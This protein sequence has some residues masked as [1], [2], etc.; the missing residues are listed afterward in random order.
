VTRPDFPL[1]WDNSMRS[2]LVACPQKFSYE[3]LHNWK[4]LYPSVDTHAGKAFAEG[5]EVARK[6]FYL[7][8]VNPDDAI[9]DG[10]SALISAYG[11]FECPSD[12]PKSR[13]RLSEAFIYYWDTFPFHLDPAQPYRGLS[14]PMIE[15]SFALPLD[16]SLLHPITGEPIIYC[17]RAD[18]VATYAGGVTIYDDKTTKSLGP[19]WGQKWDMRAQFTGYCWA[20]ITYGIPVTQVLVRGISILKTKLDHAQTITVRTPWRI[21]VWHA[22]VVRDIRRAMEMWKEGYWDRN[23]SDSCD[24]YKGCPYKQ[25]CMHEAAEDYLSIYFARKRW[26]PL[27]RT[28]TLL[29][30]S[31]LP[32][33][34]PPTQIVGNIHDIKAITRK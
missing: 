13:N 30:A 34:P 8:G 32:I 14:G 15:F 12:S 33:L 1:I 25:P 9:A 5:L 31:G 24:S 11:D 7:N 26:D 18:M 29:D 23:E 4:S 20:A 2:S 22:Q 21:K 27:T 19:T 16:D 28:E 6:S 10:L 3:Y 17:G